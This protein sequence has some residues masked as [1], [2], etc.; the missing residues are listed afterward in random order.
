MSHKPGMNLESRFKTP[1]HLIQFPGSVNEFWRKRTRGLFCTCWI[2]QLWNERSEIGWHS[3]FHWLWRNYCLLREISFMPERS[4][5]SFS[6]SLP[7]LLLYDIHSI[8]LYQIGK[9][10]NKTCYICIRFIFCNKGCWVWTKRLVKAESI[11]YFGQIAFIIV[12]IC[13][14]F[15]KK[16]NIR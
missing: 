4:L 15:K 11:D 7:V 6:Q 2:C 3:S 9:I 16:Y 14:S 12:Y 8:V 1:L 13:L 5:I 10:K